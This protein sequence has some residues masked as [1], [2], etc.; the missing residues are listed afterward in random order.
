MPPRPAGDSEEWVPEF[1]KELLSF[2]AARH[3]DQVD[4][5]SLIG[6]LLDVM[7]PGTPLPAAQPMRSARELTMDE[8][9]ELCRVVPKV[10]ER[11]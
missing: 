10:N 2:P 7:V 4:A 3:D 1:I 11:I 5:L 6:Q 8:A 9:W